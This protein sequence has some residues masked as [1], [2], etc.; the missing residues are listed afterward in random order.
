MKAEL[1]IILT[2]Q[3]ATALQRRS[4]RNISRKV[5]RKGAHSITEIHLFARNLQPAIGSTLE[6]RQAIKS[7]IVYR[8]TS[9]SWTPLFGKKAIVSKPRSSKFGAKG[10][11]RVL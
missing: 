8:I 5:R 7:T 6:P 4:S 11:G 1:I 3:R 2:A 9:N 10:G